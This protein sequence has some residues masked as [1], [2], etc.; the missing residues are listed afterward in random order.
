VADFYIERRI[1][2]KGF[3]NIAGIDEA[4]RGA[5]FGPVVAAAVMFPS[6][7]IRKK[8]HGWLKDV[9]DSKLLS[10]KKRR[11]LYPLILKQAISV[12]VGMATNHEIDQ[13]NIL[14]A[15]KEAMKRA[16]GDM[17]EEPDFL[18]VDGLELYNVNYLQ[19]KVFKG[20]QKSITIASASIV[21]KVVRDYM[22]IKLSR[23]F[24]GYSLE[25]NKGYG[26]RE[27]YLAL[28]KLGP[29]VFHRTSFSLKCEVKKNG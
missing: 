26:T 24:H 16:V 29:T 12:G 11:K 14:W 2:K 27:H 5:L 3:G 4:G 28:E 15:S 17:A 21:A 7:Y 23:K 1:A 6:S 22:I 25:R 13:N 9:N 8:L 19:E 20:D 18:L 10:V